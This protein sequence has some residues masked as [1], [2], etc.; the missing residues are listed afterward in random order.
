[1]HCADFFDGLKVSLNRSF[2]HFGLT[3]NLHFK[4]GSEDETR[5]PVDH[6]YDLD[7]TFQTADQSQTDL[8]PWMFAAQTRVSKKGEVSSYLMVNPSQET[9][10]NCRLQLPGNT[11]NSS[12]ELGA[13]VEGKSY[14]VTGN[15]GKPEHLQV[16]LLQSVTEKLS[17]GGSAT[18]V[19]QRH[20]YTG[21]IVPINLLTLGARFNA[22]HWIGQMTC[23]HMSEINVSYTHRL[24]ENGYISVEMDHILAPHLPRAQIADYQ[25]VTF[26][27]ELK[28]Q[29]QNKFRAFV[30]THGVVGSMLEMMVAPNVK[31]TLGLQMDHHKSEFK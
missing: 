30:N 6:A 17:L 10:L 7:L 15:V 25:K 12:V 3:H 29:S 27:L 18:L 11:E 16:S 1:M 5:V 22:E 4:P 2:P 20:P 24:K 28:S 13:S 14:T 19:M 23:K 26:G 8:S 31:V 21:Q 9:A